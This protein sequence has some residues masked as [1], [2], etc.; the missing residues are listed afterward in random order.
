MRRRPFLIGFIRANLQMNQMLLTAIMSCH[1]R[2]RLPIDAFFVNAESTPFGFV[3]KN[4]MN[5]L[6][7]A[8]T[9]FAGAGVSSDEPA[10]AKLITFPSQAAELC[11]MVVALASNHQQP[12]GNDR[13]QN[14]IP[15]QKYS[16]RF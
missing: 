1:C 16:Q 9:G 15:K 2:K 10:P 7:N 11:D 8:G 5:E 13:Q 4:L 14:S 12:V 3:L 6:V